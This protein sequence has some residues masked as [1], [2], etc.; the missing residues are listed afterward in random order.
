MVRAD[1]EVAKAE[2]T[3]WPYCAPLCGICLVHEAVEF[4]G[5]NKYESLMTFTLEAKPGSRL[6]LQKNRDGFSVQVTG[7]VEREDKASPDLSQLRTLRQ[8]LNALRA[9]GE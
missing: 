2:T 9:G 7:S 4:L 3:Q 1:A 6:I 8:K 5:N